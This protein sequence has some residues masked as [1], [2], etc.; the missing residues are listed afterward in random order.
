MGRGR[1]SCCPAPIS[2]TQD[3]ARCHTDHHVTT[4]LEGKDVHFIRDWP[5]YSPDLNPIEQTWRELDRRWSIKFGSASDVAELKRQVAEIWA[6][7][8]QEFVNGYVTSFKAKAAE[9]VAKKGL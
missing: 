4:Y 3:G 6:S 7:F 1:S 5:P 8:T 2:N 9:C